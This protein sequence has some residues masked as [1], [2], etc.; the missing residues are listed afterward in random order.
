MQQETR[1]RTVQYGHFSFASSLTVLYG[2]KV[3]S[4]SLTMRSFLSARGRRLGLFAASSLM[5]LIGGCAPNLGPAPKLTGPEDYASSRSFEAPAAAWPADDWWTAYGDPQLDSLIDQALKGSPDLREAEARFRSAAAQAE[6]ARSPFLPQPS[7]DFSAAPTR[8]SKEIGFPPEFKSFLPGGYHT[9]TRLTANLD[10]QLDFFGRNRA[11]LAA[12]ISTAEAAKADRAAARLQLSAAVATAYAD[13]VRF[14]ADRDA[15][16]EALKVRKETLDLVGQ[17]LRNGLETRG[18]FSQQHATV[19][20]AQADLDRLDLQIVQARHQLATLLGKGPDAGL[21]IAR[22]ATPTL[23]PLGVPPDLAVDLI[24]RRPDITAARLRAEAAAQRERVAKL[25]FYPNISLSGY[26]GAQALDIGSLFN[27]DANIGSIGPAIHLPN[28]VGGPQLRGA[29]RQARG[30]YDAA[31]AEYDKTLSNALRE[32]AD[33]IASQRSLAI[34]VEDAR[35]ALTANE[36]AWQAAQARYKG[37]LSPYL[38]V[39]T[40]ENAVLAARRNLADLEAQSLSLDVALVRAL[41][42]GFRAAD[43]KTASR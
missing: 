24:G 22:P 35:R 37:G 17:R 33:A 5:V 8:E 4:M 6:Q 20:A 14:Y 9:N 38:N 42:G 25:D 1:F 7:A 18:E 10:W 30:E 40:A 13:L 3:I 29:Y 11:A 28:F 34:Q 36:D 41:G 32:V 23:H 31:V 16:E 15:A 21:D 43:L 26:Y 27:R 19:P 39:L 12:A 2:Q